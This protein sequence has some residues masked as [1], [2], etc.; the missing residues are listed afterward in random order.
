[1]LVGYEHLPD[2]KQIRQI[3]RAHTMQNMPL[4]IPFKRGVVQPTLCLKIG[5]NLIKDQYWVFVGM[6]TV[7]LLLG[8][9]VPF[10]IL[11][12]PLMC[13]IYLS[14]FQCRRG[15]KVEFGNLFKGFDYFGESVIA[16][17]FHYIPMVIIIVPFYIF[18]YG[19]LFVIMASARGDQP[20][21]AKFMVFF[22]LLMILGL[23]MALL[24]ILISVLFVFTYPLIVERK[25]SGIDAVK[26]SVRAGLAN[27][28]QLLGLLFLNGLLAFGGLLL[29]YVG[30]F[31][32]LPVTFGAIATAYEQVF[33]LGGGEGTR[34]PPPPPSFN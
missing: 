21:P 20:D 12:G 34:L 27:F 31:L 22:A 4:G 28:W 33:S 17:L 1:M 30:M 29:C 7:G 32:I 8:S 6:S 16:T 24:L 13:G 26:L 25:L 2:R 23:V 10:G 3:K 18:S 11:L 9:F 15:Q 14:L 5:W 19:G